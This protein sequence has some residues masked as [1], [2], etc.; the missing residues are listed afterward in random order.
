M[1]YPLS[2]GGDA[3][4]ILGLPGCLRE[5]PR[6]NSAPMSTSDKARIKVDK[7]T[8]QAKEKW[9]RATGDRRLQVEGR[10][11]QV[12]ADVRSFGEKV[13]DRFRRP[14]APRR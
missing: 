9:G 8:G 2:Y 5:R 6:G 13:K 4:S 11:D 14:N 1:L 3:G 12:N 7:L 10:A